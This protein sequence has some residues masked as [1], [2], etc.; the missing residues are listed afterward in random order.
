M[1]PVSMYTLLVPLVLFTLGKPCKSPF[2]LSS[3]TLLGMPFLLP[4]FAVYS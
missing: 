4:F 1:N 3:I 2:L